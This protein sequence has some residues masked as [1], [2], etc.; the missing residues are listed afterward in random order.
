MKNNYTTL[1]ALSTLLMTICC[2]MA[3]FKKAAYAMPIQ[4]QWSDSLIS[5]K[6]LKRLHQMGEV[7]PIRHEWMIQAVVVAND[8]YDN[9][10]KSIVIQDSTGGIMLLLDGQNLF[11]NYPVGTLIRLRLKDLLLSD[12]RRMIQL[13][14]AVDSSSGSLVTGGIPVPLFKQHLQILQDNYPVIPIQVQFKNLHDSLQGRLIQL[15]AIEFS[16]ADTAQ[17]F[18]DKKNKLG[19]SRAL[20]FCTGGTIYL[21]TSG[22]ADFAGVQVPNGNGSILGVYSVFNSEKQLLLRHPDDILFTKSRCSGAAWLKN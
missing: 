21:R 17:T 4:D 6:Q 5:I 18:A 8:E 12:Y 19:A 3:C 9:W 10:Y 15:S 20:K 16:A 14:G 13:V 1:V 11:Q 2:C 7:E 22:Y